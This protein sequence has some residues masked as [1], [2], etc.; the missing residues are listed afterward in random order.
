MGSY[1]IT[2]FS[3][4]RMLISGVYMIFVSNVMSVCVRCEVY[5]PVF[6]V[7]SLLLFIM[8]LYGAIDHVMAQLGMIMFEGRV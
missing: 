3:F 5:G 7:S 4:F 2:L 6:G 1:H 8:L